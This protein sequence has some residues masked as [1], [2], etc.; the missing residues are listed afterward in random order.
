MLNRA[1]QLL[2]A[3]PAVLGQ[4][5]PGEGAKAGPQLSTVAVCPGFCKTGLMGEMS[6]SAPRTPEQ[7]RRLAGAPAGQANR[8][9]LPTR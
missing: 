5:R 9:A 8:L 4:P 7:V 1:V 3:S 2:V 6:A